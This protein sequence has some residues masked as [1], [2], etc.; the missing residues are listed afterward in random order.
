MKSKTFLIAAVTTAAVGILVAVLVQGYTSKGGDEGAPRA[1]K[2]IRMVYA[3]SSGT[4]EVSKPGE[5]L[6]T[7]VIK[8][9]AP[10]AQTEGTV[11]S[12]E[13]CAPD[14]RGISHCHNRIQMDTGGELTVVHSHRMANVPCLSPGERVLVQSV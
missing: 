5:P 4:P 7:F 14:A 8:G 11:L 1:G 3:A 6:Q 13:N 10:A 9:K 2:T 12:D